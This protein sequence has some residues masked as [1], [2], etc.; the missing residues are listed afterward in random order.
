VLQFELGQRST[1][2]VKIVTQESHLMIDCQRSVID[3]RPRLAERA[4]R[5]G[6][7][8]WL[9]LVFKTYTHDRRY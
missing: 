7:T 1:L 6:Q 3:H 4:L 9:Q 5:M 2:G 8:F